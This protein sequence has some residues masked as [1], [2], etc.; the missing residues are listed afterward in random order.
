MKNARMN[1]LFSAAVIAVVVGTVTSVSAASY[2]ETYVTTSAEGLRQ[3][4]VSYADLD[5]KT[6]RGQ[7][8]LYYRMARAADTVCGSRNPS[9]AGGAR[10]VSQNKACFK[11]AMG[12][13][14]AQTSTSQVVTISN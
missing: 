1:K 2:D 10:Q 8:T 12:Q 14:L 13:G 7:E 3:V 6:D 5:L 11:R 4:T 9:K